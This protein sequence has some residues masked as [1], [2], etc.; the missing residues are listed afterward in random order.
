[1]KSL[2]F[3]PPVLLFSLNLSTLPLQLS[4]YTLHS[5]EP[6]H[7]PPS[8]GPAM[9][10]EAPQNTD[11]PA[12][13]NTAGDMEVGAAAKA[14]GKAERKA[15]KAEAKSK[16]E[17]VKKLAEIAQEKLLQDLGASLASNARA[18]TFACGG[19][20]PFKTEDIKSDGVKAN[21][22]DSD[23]AARNSTTSE[24]KP[25][26]TSNDIAAIDSIQVRFGKS[27]EGITVVFKNTGPSTL[28]L[29]QLINACQPA[30]FGRAGEAV[31]D[32]QY[33]KAGKLDKSDFAT[34]FC[35]YEAGIIDVI[36]QL[37]VPQL[38]HEKHAR[39]IK[40]SLALPWSAVNV[41]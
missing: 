28:E 35:P 17:K 26:K 21:N 13:G 1:M 34:S 16:K 36:T 11:T 31:L 23:A 6:Q 4:I 18:A 2:V 41:S 30:S 39:S 5:L 19:S 8:K 33:R 32:E 7:Q 37:L 25:E 20:V 24:Y 27:G 15:Q 40:V 38:E 12:R 10:G 9:A 3:S 22:D 29:G 14:E